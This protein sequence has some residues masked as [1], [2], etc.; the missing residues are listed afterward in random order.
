[1][2]SLTSSRTRN[3]RCLY[4]VHAEEL[5]CFGLAGE[6]VVR[7][8]LH[9]QQPLTRSSSSSSSVRVSCVKEQAWHE[10]QLPYVGVGDCFQAS[11]DEILAV[12]HLFISTTERSRQLVSK[13]LLNVP[14]T[15]LFLRLG[16]MLTTIIVECIWESADRHSVA[17]LVL[18]EQQWQQPYPLLC[19]LLRKLLC[20]S[21]ATHSSSRHSSECSGSSRGLSCWC[22]ACAVVGTTAL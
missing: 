8:M 10:P 15:R 3:C 17:G 11:L 22:F 18:H 2:N 12:P 21:W 14:C 5:A 9:R 1:M 16:I 6:T 13:W 7:D 4:G 20:I 19:L